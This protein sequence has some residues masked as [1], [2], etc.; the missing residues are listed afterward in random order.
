M[1]ALSGGLEIVLG[2]LAEMAGFEF[3]PGS[4]QHGEPGKRTARSKKAT[5]LDRSNAESLH[6]A[7][8]RDANLIR[9]AGS[10]GISMS[11]E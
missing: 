3:K 9:T 1:S 2:P 5:T 7:E 6:R 10:A 4:V 11:T 8:Q